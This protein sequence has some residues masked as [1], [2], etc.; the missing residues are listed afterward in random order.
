MKKVHFLHLA[1]LL[2][3]LSGTLAWGQEMK[4]DEQAVWQLEEDYWR[5]VKEQDLGRYLALWDERFVGWPS[6]SGTP[7]GKAN[8]TDWMAPLRADPARVFDYELN[9]EAVRS[10]GDIVVTHYLAWYVFRDV[11]TRGVLERTPLRITHTWRRHG[12]SWQIIAGM[13]APHTVRE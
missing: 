13:S 6:S 7:M 3:A 4:D 10:F 12:D 2:I 9:K 11:N 8:I 5:Y 1:V